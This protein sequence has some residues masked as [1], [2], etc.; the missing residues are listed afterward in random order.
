VSTDLRKE[1]VTVTAAFISQTP[2]RVRFLAPL[3][4]RLAAWVEREILGPV[5]PGERDGNLDL[6]DAPAQKDQ[7]REL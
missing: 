3:K 1:L 4:A 5:H 6:W 2:A 7:S